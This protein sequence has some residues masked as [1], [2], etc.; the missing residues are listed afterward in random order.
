MAQQAPSQNPPQ[1]P[2]QQ[3]DQQRFKLTFTVPTTDSEACK[4]AIFATGAGTVPGSKYR[5]VS[6]ETEG[7]GQFLPCEGARPS[8]GEG[9]GLE[10][11]RE[12]RV[13]VC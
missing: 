8:L 5:N 2:Q 1:N 7:S 9:G 6:F 11:V 13:E 12:V 10:V 3:Q 4:T